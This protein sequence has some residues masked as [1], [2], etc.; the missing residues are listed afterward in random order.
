MKPVGPER[1][2]LLETYC[3]CLWRAERRIILAGQIANGRPVDLTWYEVQG[4]LIRHAAACIKK[5]GVF[6]HGSALI[7]LQIA[8]SRFAAEL[9]GHPF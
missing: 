2:H 1:K 8:R 5:R 3:K 7:K 9:E 6:A 4:P